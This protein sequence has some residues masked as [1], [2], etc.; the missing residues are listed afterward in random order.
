MAVSRKAERPMVYVHDTMV[1]GALAG[2]QQE[3]LTIRCHTVAGRWQVWYTQWYRRQGGRRR[4][5][6]GQAMEAKC[7][8]Q[9]GRQAQAPLPSTPRRSEAV[10][11][12]S[13]HL[14]PQL[15][16]YFYMSQRAIICSIILQKKYVTPDTLL[17]FQPEFTMFRRLFLPPT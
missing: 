6:A 10:T 15:A 14:P 12:A 9:A 8:R 1:N 3:T 16:V 11:G 4:H 17:R 7:M 2:S 13:K 5:P